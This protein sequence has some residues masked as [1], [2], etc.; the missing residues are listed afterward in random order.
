MNSDITKNFFVRHVRSIFLCTIFA[1]NFPSIEVQAQKAS[2]QR[3]QVKELY[4]LSKANVLADGVIGLTY[5]RGIQNQYYSAFKKLESQETLSIQILR[6]YFR[7]AT[8]AGKVYIALLIEKNDPLVGREILSSLSH[9]STKVK[10]RDG[11]MLLDFTVGEIAELLL[12]PDAIKRFRSSQMILDSEQFVQYTKRITNLERI[13]TLSKS[14]NFRD[15]SK[16]PTSGPKVAS[17]QIGPVPIEFLKKL[18]ANAGPAGKLYVAAI[19]QKYFPLDGEAA[20]ERLAADPTKVT[21]ESDSGSRICSVSEIAK[22]LKQ[23]GSFEGFSLTSG[24]EVH[25]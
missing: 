9:D 20:L 17:I 6:H 2:T 11:C 23:F 4:V 8:P 14:Q 13:E 1:V 24:H 22:A 25:K 16:F 5:P 3:I 19:M 7:N 12:N 15:L 10:Y 21:Y 18:N